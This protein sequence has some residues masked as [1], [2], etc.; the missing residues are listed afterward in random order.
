MVLLW[1]SFLK[2]LKNLPNTVLYL[3]LTSR[4]SGDIDYTFRTS[5][6]SHCLA[7]NQFSFGIYVRYMLT[8]GGLGFSEQHA[9]LIHRQPYRLVPERLLVLSHYRPADHTTKTAIPVPYRVFFYA[10]NRVPLPS[11]AVVK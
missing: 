2:I 5:E 10:T 3:C 1:I 4:G 8:D 7:F 9:H 11:T 6:F